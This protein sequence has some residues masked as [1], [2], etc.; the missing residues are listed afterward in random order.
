MRKRKKEMLSGFAD[1]DEGF[2]EGDPPVDWARLDELAAVFANN[3]PLE[4]LRAIYGDD[5]IVP[6]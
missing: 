2:A 5:L 3:T 4:A 1:A 6:S